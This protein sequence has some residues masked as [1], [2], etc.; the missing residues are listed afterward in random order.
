MKKPNYTEEYFRNRLTEKQYKI[1]RE[2]GTEPAFSGEYL[3]LEEDGRY[4]CAGCGQPVF[5]STKKF[6][7]D[8]GWPSF[9]DVFQTG[10]VGFRKDSTLLLERIEVYCAHCGSH[11]GHVFE[12]GPKPTHKRYCV[13]SLAL[14][15]EPKEQ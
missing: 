10:N 14:K 4:N 7:S 2:H 11:L 6:H 15:F 8:S 12:D 1:L 3:N 13:N 9:Y 5:E